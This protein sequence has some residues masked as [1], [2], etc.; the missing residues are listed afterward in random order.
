M[1]RAKEEDEFKDPFDILYQLGLLIFADDAPD[2]PEIIST[3][4]K[5]PG[6]HG[7]LKGTTMPDLPPHVHHWVLGAFLMS[8]SAIG[9]VWFALDSARRASELFQPKV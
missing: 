8:A 2:F 5:E 4:G 6:R 3:W 7:V 1:S 9:K